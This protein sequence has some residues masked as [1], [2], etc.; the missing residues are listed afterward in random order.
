MAYVNAIRRQLNKLLMIN[1]IGA[2]Q[3][4][5]GISISQKSVRTLQLTMFYQT[6][7]ARKPPNHPRQGRNGAVRCWCTLFAASAYH[8]YAAGVTAALGVFFVSGDLD[9]WPLTL[10]F[11]LLRAT[12][13]KR[14][15]CEFRANPFSGSRDIWGTNKNEQT[16]KSQT[17]VKT[18][19]YLRAVKH[20]WE[21]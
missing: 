2:V 15:P 13:Q 19:P 21:P 18:E 7:T 17:A 14:L 5:I 8:S 11:K 6:Y 9:L 16:K 20:W 1:F 4:V 3:Y 10:T 12:D